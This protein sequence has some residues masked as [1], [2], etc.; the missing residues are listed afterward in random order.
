MN[1]GTLRGQARALKNE[2]GALDS[3]IKHREKNNMDIKVKLK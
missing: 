2:R 1:L 3:A